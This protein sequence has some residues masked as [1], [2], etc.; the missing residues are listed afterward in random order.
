MT[1]ERTMMTSRDRPSQD[2]TKFLTSALPADDVG[3]DKK[4]LAG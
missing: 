1:R 3:V 4:M 2:L